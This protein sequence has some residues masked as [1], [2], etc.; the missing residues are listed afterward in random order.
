MK[1]I[2]IASNIL[3]LGIILF[4]SCNN[5]TNTNVNTNSCTEQVSDYSNRP[6]TGKINAHFASII[7]ARYKSDRGKKFIWNG[8]KATTVE[9]ASS[10]WF[11]LETLKQFIWEIE[12]Q[13]CSAGCTDSL[14]IRFYYARYVD[15]NDIMW[16][17]LGYN[18]NPEYANRHT[19]FGVPTY[20]DGNKNR[21]FDPWI[22]C[23]KPFDMASTAKPGLILWRMGGESSEA[24]NHGSLIPPP[25]GGG[26]FGEN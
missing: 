17:E 21:D 2:L 13:T 20:F 16:P 26:T 11:G 4:Q 23:R 24:Q 8:D 3:F 6:W 22:G 19:I 25:A 1:K 9:D 18:A 14:G 10:I 12:S 7:S 5:Q 15:T